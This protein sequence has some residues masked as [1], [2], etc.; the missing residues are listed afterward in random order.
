MPILVKHVD[1]RSEQRPMLITDGI[2]VNELN[3]YCFP[4]VIC[5]F[6]F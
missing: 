5:V 3:Y 6:G 1:A 4:F 2:G